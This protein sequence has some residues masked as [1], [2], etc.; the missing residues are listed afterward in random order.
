MAAQSSPL[1]QDLPLDDRSDALKI[2]IVVLI[3][4]SSFFVILRLGVSIK[5]RN[6][7]LLTDHFLWTGHALAIA[8]AVFC[9][10]MAE[11]GGGKHI[12]DPV[13]AD[14]ANLEKYLRYLWLGQ[15]LNLYGMA[16]VKLSICAYIFMLNFSKKFRILIW[17]SVVVHIG[18]NFVFPTII[19]FGECTPYSKHWK[20]TEPGSCWST[21]PKVISGYTGAAT[22][23]FTDLIYT[24]APLV[25]IARVQL[26]KRT[27]WGVRIVF[28]LGLTTTTISALKLYEM[29]SLNE[30]PDPT[31]DSVNLSIYAI[32]EVFVGVFT[33][34]LPPLRKF[35]DD[36]LRKILPAGMMSSRATG[37]SYALKGFSGRSEA[38]KDPKATHESDGDSDYAILE[39]NRGRRPSSNDEI[40]KVTRVSVTIN[41][42]TSERHRGDD[43]V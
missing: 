29:K 39:E 36:I 26:N 42:K 9:Y 25:Y 38:V 33:A 3:V 40:M 19:L 32:A 12:W 21:K 17:V 41:D 37:D 31:W 20:T 11:V 5:N 28:L 18:L 10:M 6:F 16:L 34:C 23:I 22:N 8:G 43:W 24:F 13:F 30:S 2:P 35:F 1:P 27:I 15:L 14:P 7:L 4:F